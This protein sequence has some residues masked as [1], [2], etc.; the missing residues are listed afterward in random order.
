MIQ[1]HLHT[2]SISL[3]LSIGSEENKIYT[4]H[5]QLT[6][7]NTVKHSNTRKEILRNLPVYNKK[8]FEYKHHVNNIFLNRG[9]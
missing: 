9:T 6:C 5:H 2:I 8:N 7:K 4:C 3:T 1:L